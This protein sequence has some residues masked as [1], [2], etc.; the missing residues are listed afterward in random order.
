MSLLLCDSGQEEWL[1]RE[2][3]VRKAS[4]EVMFSDLR[5]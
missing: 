5:A 3:R 1:Y 4:R 2:T